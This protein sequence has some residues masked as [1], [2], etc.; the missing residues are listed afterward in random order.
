[1][2]LFI[3]ILIA[4]FLVLN[5]SLEKFNKNKNEQ[6]FLTLFRSFY[7]LEIRENGKPKLILIDQN[8]FVKIHF[9]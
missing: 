5:P 9:Y 6:A 2:L 7:D 8:I 3:L 1:M 4:I